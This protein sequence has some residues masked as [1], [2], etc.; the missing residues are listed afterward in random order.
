MTAL[1]RAGRTICGSGGDVRRTILNTTNNQLSTGRFSFNGVQT[2]DRAHPAGTTTCPGGTNS[3]ACGAG[4][5]MADFLLGYLSQVADGTPIPPVTKY[6]SNWAGFVNDTWNVTRSL[7]LTIGLR[8]EYQTR[9]HTSPYLPTQD[10]VVAN[11]EFTGK[12]AVA[13]GP[14]GQ[15]A[16]EHTRIRSGALEPA[17]TLV[18]CLSVGLPDNCL[19][20]QK[21][22]WQPRIWASPTGS[23][24][25]PWSGRGA[26]HPSRAHSTRPPRCGKLRQLA[27]RDHTISLD[28]HD[29]RLRERRCRRSR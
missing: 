4:D 23:A 11:N 18:S 9:F 26:E 3:S 12:I 24:R 21:N 17:G 13:T 25:R 29:P 14:N 22:Q 15:F 20:S 6:F 16:N 2:R 28:V 5:A 8:Y 7:T 19:V 10:P 27:A 1:I